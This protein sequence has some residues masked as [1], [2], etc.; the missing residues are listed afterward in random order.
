[1]KKAAMKRIS[2]I[3]RSQEERADPDQRTVGKR[4]AFVPKKTEEI[5]LEN[6]LEEIAEAALEKRD[7][8]KSVIVEEADQDLDIDGKNGVFL[9]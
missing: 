9:N 1:M 3:L 2:A 7:A 6:V 4:E 5:D 8:I